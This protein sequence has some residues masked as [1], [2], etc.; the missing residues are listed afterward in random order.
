MVSQ[1]ACGRGRA[2]K[3]KG[4]ERVR[5]GIRRF[6]GELATQL[7]AFGAGRSPWR[8]GKRLLDTRKNSRLRHRELKPTAAAE[9]LRNHF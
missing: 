4:K 7:L 2:T 5:S 8:F 9:V 3:A 6:R 1:M